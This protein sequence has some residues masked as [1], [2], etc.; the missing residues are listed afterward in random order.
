MRKLLPLLAAVL[1]CAC[2]VGQSAL[3]ES[4]A[5]NLVWH[6]GHFDALG[7]LEQDFFEPSEPWPQNPNHVQVIQT[8]AN[9]L[10]SLSVCEPRTS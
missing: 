6:A 10:D 5:A 3:D 4:T 7:Q 8:D 1:M 2:R 9:S